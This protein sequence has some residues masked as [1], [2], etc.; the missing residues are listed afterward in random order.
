MHV[1]YWAS[2]L[3][4]LCLVLPCTVINS[5]VLCKLIRGNLFI[6]LFSDLY[7]SIA[8]RIR[9]YANM[10]SHLKGWGAHHWKLKAYA[11]LALRWLNVNELLMQI[12]ICKSID[13]PKCSAQWRSAR[14]AD[15]KGNLFCACNPT[16]ARDVWYCLWWQPLFAPM[17]PTYRPPKP[18]NIK[19]VSVGQLS[20]YRHTQT[21]G[22]DST[23]RLLLRE[24]GWVF[25]VPHPKRI[26]KIEDG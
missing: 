20:W 18:R 10:L 25:S 14:A 3:A 4:I 6:Y 24:T 15:A 26:C 13:F 9:R 21:W 17:V 11:W 1:D 19:P 23:I 7:V 16:L 5:V 2:P 12:T 8:W 22:K